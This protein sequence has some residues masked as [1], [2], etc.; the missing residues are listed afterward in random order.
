MAT[1]VMSNSSPTNK[2]EMP[3]TVWSAVTARAMPAP[4]LRTTANWATRSTRR[5]A[6]D[7]C[8]A[9]RTVSATGTVRARPPHR[10]ELTRVRMV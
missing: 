1:G 3:P 10:V 9:K 6:E 7:V 2:K 5:W 4:T 8:M